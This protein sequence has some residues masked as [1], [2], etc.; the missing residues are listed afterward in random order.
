MKS[1]LPLSLTTRLVLSHLIIGI[2]SIGLISV[3]AAHFIIDR[4]RREVESFLEDTAFLV[5]NNLEQPMMEAGG[6][7]QLTSLMSSVLGQ[8]F[9]QRPEIKFTLYQAD[10]KILTTNDKTDLGTSQAN[11]IAVEVEVALS[12]VD[13]EESRLDSI[14]QENYYVAIPISHQNVV[15]GALRLSGVYA[16]QMSASYRSLLLL[17]VIGVLLILAVILEAWWMAGMITRPI[18]AL[19]DVAEQLSQGNLGVRAS[20]TGPKEMQRL[21]ETVNQMASH[22]QDNMEGLRAFVANAS[23]ELR[24]PITAIKLNVDALSDGAVDDRAVAMRFLSQVQDELEL[25]TRTVTDLLDLSKIEAG[26]GRTQYEPVDTGALLNETREFW[27]VRAHQAGL[28]L[29]TSVMPGGPNVLGNE[30]Q[31]RRLVNNLVE[32]AIKHT[33]TGGE[34]ELALINNPD[35]FTVRLEVKDNGSGIAED[36]I[37]RIFERFYRVEPTQIKNKKPS[38]SGLGLAIAKSIVEAHG[39]KIGVTSKIG[40]GSTFWVELPTIRSRYDEK[41]TQPRQTLS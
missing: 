33:P 40:S 28:E 27:K 14:G 17:G 37:P 23:H 21:A 32:N 29:K 35:K 34:V 38:G 24:T 41:K 20:P 4:G 19:T 9:F 13:G 10:G 5:A 6:S 1:R 39:G 16:D 31:L 12:G 2:F 25:M 8:F 26:R 3:I 36:H 11:P 15:Y 22:L 7:G 18:R 30:D